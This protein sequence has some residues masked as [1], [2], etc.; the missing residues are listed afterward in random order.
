MRKT[1]LPK[2]ALCFLLPTL[3]L[4][5][6][7]FAAPARQPTIKSLIQKAELTG[8]NAQDG[9]LVGTSVAISGNT[10]VVGAFGSDG[11]Q[12]FVPGAVYVYTKPE[13]GWENMTQ[14]AILTP[15]DS[16]C[17]YDFGYYLAISGN[18][19]VVS[20]DDGEHVYVEPQGGWANMTETAI[21]TDSNGPASGGPVAIE[22]NT[23]AVGSQVDGTQII[24]TLEVYVRPTGGWQTTSTPTAI[25]SQPQGQ[26][27]D[28]T[29]ESVVI[30]GNMIAAVGGACSEIVCQD[31]VYLY[32]KP[33]NG[34]RGKIKPI[35]TLSTSDAS[36]RVNTGNV[37]MSGNTVV[38]TAV[39]TS[40]GST[41]GIAYVWVEPA[42]GWQNMTETAQLTDGNTFYDQFGT[43]TAI[44]GNTVLVGTPSAIDIQTGADYRGAV[45]VYKKPT[46]GWQT[47]SSPNAILLSS[48]WTQ[49]DGFG[50]S[51]AAESGIAIV[52]EP[53]GPLSTYVGAAYIFEFAF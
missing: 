45:Y 46:G 12:Y 34:W 2:F 47:T 27:S 28:Q 53:Y 35:A 10:A 49:N 32:S 5:A 43:S 26:V 38:A 19:I 25:L 42:G 13:S 41:P 6:N 50:S 11:F 31:F 4:C 23:I 51:V 22:G 21:L 16:A 8:S 24:G 1:P 17:S 18:T 29:S 20:C 40:N 52:G 15:S 30:S 9:S 36:N 3:F 33:S 7:G 37:S 44:V 48:D 39:G 14:V